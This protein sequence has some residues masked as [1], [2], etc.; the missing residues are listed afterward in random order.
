MTSGC[1]YTVTA[2][3][4]LGV[5]KLEC[6]LGTQSANPHNDYCQHFVDTGER[7]QNFIRDTGSFLSPLLVVTMIMPLGECVFDQN[8]M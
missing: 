5:K 1:L 8:P 2:D 7:P 4:R 3:L 6:D